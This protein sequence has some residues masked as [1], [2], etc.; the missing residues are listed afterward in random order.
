MYSTSSYVG[1]FIST[2]S[3]HLYSLN[4]C[5]RSFTPRSNNSLSSL[6]RNEGCTC[7]NDDWSMTLPNVVLT[8]S[9]R[10]VSV[11]RCKKVWKNSEESIWCWKRNLNFFLMIQKINKKLMQEKIESCVTKKNPWNGYKNVVV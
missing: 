5:R 4:A 9:L 11:C 7:M 8:V 10:V 1:L 3:T 6:K 2:Q